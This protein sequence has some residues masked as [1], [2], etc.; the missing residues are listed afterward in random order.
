MTVHIG[1][2]G[3]LAIKKETTKGV[4]ADTPDVF[5]PF[6]EESILTNVNLDEDMPVMGHIFARFKS[7]LGIRSHGGEI[8]IKAEPNTAGYVLDMIL[9]KGTTTGASSPY[10]HPFTL[11]PSTMPKAYTWDIQ[12]G[13]VVNRFIGAEVSELGVD[14]DKNKMVFKLK[15]SALK[16]FIV[17]EVASVSGSGPYTITLKT[18]YDPSPTD[19]LVV[20]DI[21]TLVKSDDSTINFAVASVPNGTTL[22]TTTDVSSLSD[23]DLIFIRA[24]TPSFSLK[25]DFM[26]ALTEFRF[27]SN[28]AAAL[29]AAQTRV[30]IGSRWNLMYKFEADEGA[31]RSGGFDP[32]ALVRTVGDIEVPL[33]AAFDL[34]RDMNRYLTATGRALVIRHFSEDQLFELRVTVN[35]FRFK[36]NPPKVK[37]GE[38]VY[39]ESTLIPDYLTADGQAFDIKVLN[40]VASI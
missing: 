17:R 19:G 4:V 35:A 25:N 39:S 9:T 18:N 21:M 16:S 12:K 14:F 38:P 24:A 6:Y 22:T 28:A 8:T 15:M 2:K 20:D 11:D 30:E 23:G 37:S 32:A 26:W 10:T 7:L 33:K 29:S 13:I 5:I 36:E 27:G 34:P 40:A 31:Q 1:N 3:Y